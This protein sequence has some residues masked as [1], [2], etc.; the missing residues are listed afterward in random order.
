MH[1]LPNGSSQ[2]T[3]FMPD[4]VQTP[5]LCVRKSDVSDSNSNSNCAAAVMVGEQQAVAALPAG[6]R[7]RHA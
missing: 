6:A 4:S 5:V 3:F 7:G 1:V 2:R